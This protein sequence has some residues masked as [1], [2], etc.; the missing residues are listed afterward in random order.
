MVKKILIFIL[1]IVSLCTLSP[2]ELTANEENSQVCFYQKN[3][4]DELEYI[5]VDSNEISPCGNACTPPCWD[6]DE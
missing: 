6:V 2:I 3:E 4:Q 5:C 1:F